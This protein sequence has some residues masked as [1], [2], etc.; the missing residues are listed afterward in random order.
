MDARLN[1]KR[2]RALMAYIRAEGWQMERPN[3]RNSAMAYSDD[4]ARNMAITDRARTWLRTEHGMMHAA[5]REALIAQAF[6]RLRGEV[7]SND[8]ETVRVARMDE[9]QRVAVNALSPR[10]RLRRLISKL[11]P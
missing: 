8:T 4:H 9:G 3:P 6:R 5:R 2:L 7:V 11:D 1:A 10:E